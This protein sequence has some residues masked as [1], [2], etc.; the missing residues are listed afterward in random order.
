[1]NKILLSIVVIFSLLFFIG[2]GKQEEKKQ[3]KVGKQTILS[4]K[5]S[6]KENNIKQ[7][8]LLST[9]SV[10]KITTNNVVIAN[11]IEKETSNF[12]TLLTAVQN[13][14]QKSQSGKLLS[15]E[16]LAKLSL[17]AKKVYADTLYRNAKKNY[18]KN[19]VAILVKYYDYLIDN[20]LLEIL[21]VRH[22]T[23]IS[24]LRVCTAVNND[25]NK[26]A[27]EILKR[28]ELKVINSND[29]MS[30][31]IFYSDYGD[32][33]N[34]IGKTDMAIEMFK[35]QEKAAKNN[36][37]ALQGC[38]YMIAISGKEPEKVKKKLIEFIKTADPKWPTFNMGINDLAQMDTAREMN[39]YQSFL[40]DK[41]NL[42]E[43]NIDS[44]SH[45]T[46][47]QIQNELNIKYKETFNKNRIALEKKCKKRNNNK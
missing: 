23:K 6:T 30:K 13:N 27:I 45:E 26:L 8:N 35:Q 41:Y 22:A 34:A 28:I 18:E 36:P 29:N 31:R 46:I 15:P 7:E 1:M 16:Q 39:E 47:K 10:K 37:E 20:N 3:T 33:Y 19:N 24:S 43:K 38:K 12:D 2:C 44:V 17:S 4:Q 40:F 32:V 42:S 25:N 21:P 14:N 9:N 5:I 11:E